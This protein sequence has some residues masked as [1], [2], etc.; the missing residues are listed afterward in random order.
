MGSQFVREPGL[1]GEVVRL[2]GVGDV[3]VPEPV[4]VFQ[5]QPEKRAD[6]V[7]LKKGGDQE[8]RPGLCAAVPRVPLGRRGNA[9]VAEVALPAA[10]D[11]SSSRRLGVR[12]MCFLRSSRGCGSGA[13]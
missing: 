1:A 3:R 6:V 11:F 5:I 13:P 7:G 8:K 4:A 2:P 10:A 12:L 9:G